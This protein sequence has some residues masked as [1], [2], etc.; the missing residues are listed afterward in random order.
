MENE[1]TGKNRGFLSDVAGWFSLLVDMDPNIA[2]KGENM[3]TPNPTHAPTPT[4]IP[5]TRHS[6]RVRTF[7][8]AKT[9]NAVAT[10]R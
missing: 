1:M 6:P 8:S 4:A 2:P 3:G 9:G 5:K 10:V 7:A